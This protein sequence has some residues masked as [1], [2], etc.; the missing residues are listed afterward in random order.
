[1]PYRAGKTLIMSGGL[2]E[3]NPPKIIKII[4]VDDA[5]RTEVTE[6]WKWRHD[7]ALGLQPSP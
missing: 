7:M 4:L 2:A 3:R 6:R 1:M 5:Q